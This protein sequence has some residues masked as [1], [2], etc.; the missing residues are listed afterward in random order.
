MSEGVGELC[1]WGSRVLDITAVIVMPNNAMLLLCSV[2]H[3][4]SVITSKT[5]LKHCFAYI[6]VL[7][8]KSQVHLSEQLVKDNL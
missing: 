3:Y 5:D 4:E 6:H 7:D 1:G 2:W 8:L